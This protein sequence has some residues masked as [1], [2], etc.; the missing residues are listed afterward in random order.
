MMGI[1][2]QTHYG[3][4]IIKQIAYRYFTIDR[5]YHPNQLDKV[6][7]VREIKIYPIPIMITYIF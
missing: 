5:P 4:K 6:G 2:D 1:E 7:E 3:D